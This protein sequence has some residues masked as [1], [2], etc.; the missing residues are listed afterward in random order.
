VGVLA[1]TGVRVARS[2]EMVL[3]FSHVVAP[4][5]QPKGEAAQ[6]FADCVNQKL[7]GRVRVEV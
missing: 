3:K 6:L 4:K 1:L 5:G 7:E 2:D